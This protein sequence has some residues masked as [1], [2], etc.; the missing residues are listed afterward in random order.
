MIVGFVRDGHHSAMT[1]RL[2]L[3]QAKR[4]YSFLDPVENVVINEHKD[5]KTNNNINN[6]TKVS[7][8]AMPTDLEHGPMK[9]YLAKIQAKVL[10]PD[11]NQKQTVIKLQQLHDHIHQNFFKKQE[12]AEKEKSEQHHN[13]EDVGLFGQLWGWFESS[14]REEKLTRT[15]GTSIYN[16]SMK[17]EE[18]ADDVQEESKLESF[19]GRDIHGLYM[20]GGVGTGKTTLMVRNEGFQAFETK[21]EKEEKQKQ[22]KNK[23]KHKNTKTQKNKEKKN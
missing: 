2:T 6:N 4:L 17:I 19:E 9:T 12:L 3:A 15:K 16:E 23:Q 7:T 1:R 20:Y 11:P 18:D 14:K 5:I 21:E 10:S 22:N 8:E 13:D